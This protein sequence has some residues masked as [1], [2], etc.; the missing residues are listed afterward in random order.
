MLQKRSELMWEA[1]TLA[2][3]A[4]AAAAATRVVAAVWEKVTDTETP[5]ER[6]PGATTRRREIVWVVTSGITIALVRLVAQRAIARAWR[7]TTGEYPEQLVDTP[8]V[9]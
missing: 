5:L 9:S 8:A 1:L 4:V 7:A 2:G 3:G 6:T